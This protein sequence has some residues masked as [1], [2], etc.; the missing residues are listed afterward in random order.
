[1]GGHARL[2]DGHGRP[3][4]AGVADEQV[5]YRH[6][7]QVLTLDELDRAYPPLRAVLPPDTDSIAGLF[8]TVRQLLEQPARRHL[9]TGTLCVALHDCAQLAGPC[10][11]LTVAP[12]GT[13][14]AD[15]VTAM[16]YMLGPE[17]SRDPDRFDQHARLGLADTVLDWVTAPWRYVDP[18]YALPVLLA[19]PTALVGGWPA[20]ADEG[21]RREPHAG[22]LASFVAPPAAG[23]TRL[24][25]W[26]L[27]HPLLEVTA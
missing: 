23:T 25:A 3:W 12:P 15:A 2:V 18:A 13:A 24:G 22:L 9:L 6:A 5:V 1:M 8:V 20:V 19:A 26:Q 11:P 16:A 27:A 17:L 4:H 14:A 21:L 10:F 7:A